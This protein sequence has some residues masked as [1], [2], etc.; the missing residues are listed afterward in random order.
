MPTKTKKCSVEINLERK[1]GK[2][3]FSFDVDTKLGEIFKKKSNN[4]TKDSKV[5]KGLKFYTIPDMTTSEQYKKLLYEYGLFDN[6]GSVLIKDNRLNVAFLRTVGGKGEIEI[7]E[8]ISFARVSM[9]LK[10]IVTFIKRY[11]EEYL[12]DYKAKGNVSIEI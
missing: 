8:E 12:T 11:Y 4:T 1:D 2:T 7:E 5:W 6:Y 3:I 10:S 9:M